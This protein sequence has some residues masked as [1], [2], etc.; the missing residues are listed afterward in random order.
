MIHLQAERPDDAG[1]I[2]ALLDQAFGADRHAKVSYTYRLGIAAAPEFSLVARNDADG[3]V[4]GTV[5]CWPIQAGERLIP[6]LLLGPIAVE[7]GYK[8][9]GLGS[10]LMR[11]TLGRARELGYGLVFLVGDLGYYGRFGF[12]PA[13]PHGVVMPKEQPERLLVAELAH[14]A[15]AQAKGA[16]RRADYKPPRASTAAAR[17]WRLAL[18]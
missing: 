12:V 15:L 10:A 3:T 17:A 18:S 8:N 11:R 14:G 5:R 13:A 9:A 6:A 2:E 16:L 7:H 4:L 1:A